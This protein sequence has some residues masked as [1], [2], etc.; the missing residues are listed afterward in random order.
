MKRTPRS[1]QT[2]QIRSD[3]RNRSERYNHSGVVQTLHLQTVSDPSSAIKTLHVTG[4]H[5]NINVQDDPQASRPLRCIPKKVVVSGTP[6]EISILISDLRSSSRGKNK[7]QSE[8][9]EDRIEPVLVWYNGQLQEKERHRS[10]FPP[11]E[12]DR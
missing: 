7:I 5:G 4:P 6:E 3:Q 1:T 10:D 8:E 2:V 12:I 11:V 9:N